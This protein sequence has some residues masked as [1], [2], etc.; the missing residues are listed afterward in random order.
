[1]PLTDTAI[2]NL[3]PKEKQ[4]KVADGHGL[5]LFILPS[6]GKSWRIK[7]RFNGA[8]KSYCIGLYPTISLKHARDELLKVKQQLAG[9]IDPAKEKKNQ[10]YQQFL[11]SQNLFE[12]V[13]KRWHE[14]SHSKW[15]PDYSKKIE[16]M[17]SRWLYPRLG[18]MPINDITPQDIIRLM[19]EMESQ[20]LGDTTRRLKNYLEKIFNFAIIEGLIS[21]NPAAHISDVLKSKPPTQHQRSLPEAMIGEYLYKVQQ[22]T[23]MDIVKLGLQI[24]LHTSVRTNEMLAAEWAD[25]NLENKIW[26]IPAHKTKMSREHRIPLSEP[27]VELFTQ[28]HK[29]NG[30]FNSHVLRSPYNKDSSLANNAFL[31][32]NK[33]IAMNEHTSVHGLRATASTHMNEKGFRPDVIERHL[34]HQE[35]NRVRKAY[36]HAEYWKERT[37]L[38]NYWSEYLIQRRDEYSKSLVSTA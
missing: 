22:D 17:F 12:I 9:A 18:K 26:I 35:K 20:G 8:E 7:Y 28:L 10:K 6:G 23:G 16:Q 31:N 11:K 1:M 27:V 15:T 30:R 34:A 21:S 19:R 3:K 38:C 13:I 25:I 37:E 33:R 24:V 29:I 5:Y 2:R 14:N 36:N 4:Y 32:L